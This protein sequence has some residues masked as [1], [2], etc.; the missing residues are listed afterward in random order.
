MTEIINKSFTI[1]TISLLFSALGGIYSVN[2]LEEEH[3]QSLYRGNVVCL[4]VDKDKKSVMPKLGNKP[5]NNDAPH[6]HGFIDKGI[7]EGKFYYIEGS[8]QVI[9]ELEKTADREDVELKGVVS[10]DENSPVITIE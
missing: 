7:P 4:L 9:E 2:A 5:C 8:P 3:Q 10:G 6:A 1:L